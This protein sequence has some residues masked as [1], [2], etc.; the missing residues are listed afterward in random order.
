M[1]RNYLTTAS[2]VQLRYAKP[3]Q[4]SIY[5]EDIARG[6]AKDCRYAGQ[7]ANPQLFYSVAQHAVLV[8]MFCAKEDARWG[9]LHDASEAFIRD[10]PSGLK[11]LPALKGYRRIEARLQKAIYKRFGLKTVAPPSVKVADR[12]VAASEALALL[13]TMPAWLGKG[14]Y[15]P[16]NGLNIRPMSPRAAERAFLKR[17]DELF[18]RETLAMS[19]RRKPVVSAVAA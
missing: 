5:I 3:D 12:R 8:S 15:V 9:L 4:R 19:A 17:F 6:G 7:L 2:G 10:L 13:S 18:P 14:G 1:R 11:N 16:I